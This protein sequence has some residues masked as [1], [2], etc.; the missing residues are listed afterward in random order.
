MANG[1]DRKTGWEGE[2]LAGIAGGELHVRC[3]HQGVQNLALLPGLW[4]GAPISK[5][6]MVATRTLTARVATMKWAAERNPEPV[7]SFL[8]VCACSPHPDSLPGLLASTRKAVAP[9]LPHPEK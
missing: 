6:E 3:V 7:P 4:E 1:K 8:R 2:G 5:T 9:L